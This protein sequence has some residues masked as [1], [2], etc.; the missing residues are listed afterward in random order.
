LCPEQPFILWN[1]RFVPNPF[2]SSGF[3]PTLEIK[4]PANMNPKHLLLILA[5]LLAFTV[6][7][8]TALRAQAEH[9]RIDTSEK[10]Q[11]SAG[12]ANEHKAI[13]GN[14]KTY[15]VLGEIANHAEV[16]V[17]KSPVRK[18]PITREAVRQ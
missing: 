2:P 6:G 18:E 9:P 12:V 4:E 5:G 7:F 11:I 17:R 14:M 3:C 16:L 8:V 10:S 1:P 13:D 15:K